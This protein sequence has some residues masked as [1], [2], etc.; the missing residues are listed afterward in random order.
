[1]FT[2]L[3]RIVKFGFQGIW[4]NKGLSLQVIFIMIVAVF[5]L[6]SLFVFNELSNFLIARA[7]EK[8]NISVY[9]KKDVGEEE[10]LEVKEGLSKF[11]NGIESVSYVSKA[12]AKETFIERH[13]ND[14][15]YLSAL[16][17]I[18]DNPFLASLNIRAKDPTFYAQIS[19]FLTAE[20]FGGLVEKVS[21]YQSEEVIKKLFALT[22]N[23][24]QGGIFLSAFLVVLVFLITFNTVKLTIFSFKEEIATMKLVGASNHFIRGPFLIQGFFYGIVSILIVD[25]FFF[26]ILSIMN[27]DLQTWLFNFNLLEYFKENFSM[28][29]IWQIV[30]AFFLGVVS[31]FFAVRK[32]LKV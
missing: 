25:I 2:S 18:G 31:S 5:V 19:S 14:P 21:Y 3:K 8:V 23:I 32:Y 4:R 16:E 12:Q 6:T 24:K 20:P 22:S 30:F 13:K 7:Q 29:L 15:L 26:A 1:M 10:I 11:S 9:F 27:P 17:E 28:I